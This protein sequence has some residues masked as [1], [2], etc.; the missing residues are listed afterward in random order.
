MLHKFFIYCQWK[1]KGY[2]QTFQFYKAIYS[3]MWWSSKWRKRFVLISLALAMLLREDFQ[4]N[5]MVDTDTMDMI[6]TVHYILNVL[7]YVHNMFYL[8]PLNTHC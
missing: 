8:N 3:C 2:W 5:G 1:L 6:W 7:I 4:Q